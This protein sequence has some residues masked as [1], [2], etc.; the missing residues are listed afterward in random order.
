MLYQGGFVHKILLML[1]II[2]FFMCA[3]I[4]AAK[5]SSEE[6]QQ[7]S[8]QTVQLHELFLRPQIR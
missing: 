6:Q 3:F 4:A 1:E 8:E 7:N 2:N 5:V